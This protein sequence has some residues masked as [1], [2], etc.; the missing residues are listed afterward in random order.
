MKFFELRGAARR[1]L[2]ALG[3][4][5][6]LACMAC[7]TPG[8]SPAA[9]DLG[10]DPGGSCTPAGGPP[11]DA[12]LRASAT[13]AQERVDDAL[14]ALGNELP[15][16]RRQ[17]IHP[18]REPIQR[19]PRLTFPAM[20]D[21]EPAGGGRSTPSWFFPVILDKKQL[22]ELPPETMTGEL[23]FWLIPHGANPSDAQWRDVTECLV[24]GATREAIFA[25]DDERRPE[26]RPSGDLLPTIARRERLRGLVFEIPTRTAVAGARVEAG[27]YDLKVLPRLNALHEVAVTTPELERIRQALEEGDWNRALA[28]ARALDPADLANPVAVGD[29]RAIADRLARGNWNVT[30]HPSPHFDIDLKLLRTVLRKLA[31]QLERAPEDRGAL[32]LA[33]S[34]LER[35]MR[36]LLIGRQSVAPVSLKDPEQE[37]GRCGGDDCIRIAVGGD[38]QYH[39]NLGPL[40]RFLGML[41]PEFVQAGDAGVGQ[42]EGFVSPDVPDV[43]FVLFAGDL[44]DAAA[45]SAKEQLLLNVLGAL[46]PTS[47]YGEDGGNEMPEIRDQLARFQKPFFAVPGNHDGYAGYG[48][49]L[50]IPFDELGFA[51]EETFALFGAPRVGRTVGNAIKKPNDFIPT[52]VGWRLLNRHPRYDGLGQFQNYLGPLNVA[53]AFRGHSFVGLNSYDLKPAE[54]AAVG[55]VVLH[56][57]GGIQ[58]HSI[59]WMDDVLNRFAPADEHH[60]QFVF[61]HHDPRGAVPTK[62]EYA[63]RQFG[64]YDATDT[65]ISQLTMGH[66]GLGNSPKTGIYIPIVSFVTTFLWRGLEIGWGADAGSFQQ[67]WMRKKDFGWSAFPNPPW[68]RMFDDEAY[69]A[70]G[71]IEVINCH[72]AGRKR[73]A[74]SGPGDGGCGDARGGVSQLLFAHDNVPADGE[75]ADS[76]ERGAVFREPSD[77]Q[78]WRPGWQANSVPGQFGG[79]FGL[80]FRNGSPPEWAQHM[81]LEEGQGNARVLRMD[82]VGDAGNYHG[83]HVITLYADP[84]REPETRWYALPR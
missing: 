67:E 36:S 1:I 74:T 7:T 4:G 5:S 70:R 83:F 42:R 40:R 81:L 31:S 51:A 48:G 58:D 71:L 18:L 43:D 27:F 59:Q 57:G 60:E 30:F 44:A 21:P 66:A 84:E 72:L 6:L 17:F 9:R 41:D 32:Q 3:A 20:V 25:S 28:A 23:R 47:P 16:T 62:A 24:R 68:P 19:F 79:L 69:N 76:D 26:L 80:K 54:R 10:Y 75:W 49:L 45:G 56:W 29:L 34:R 53:F 52:L 22:G 46:P 39:G 35:P 14:A 82:D 78:L 15:E 38:F 61:M 55:G 64:L 11:S 2:L 50:N 77:G 65:Y 37:R 63:E 8:F 33:M 12:A 13:F 73:E